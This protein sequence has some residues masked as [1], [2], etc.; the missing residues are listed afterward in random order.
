LRELGE[1]LANQG[2]RAHGIVLP[3]HEGNPERLINIGW[4]QWL[5]YTEEALA[6]L[7]QYRHV[8]LAGLSMGGVLALLLAGRHRERIAGT[9]VMSTPT[10]ISGGWQLKMLP[11]ARY[12]VKW[13]YPLSRID[14]NDP[15]M[16][17]EALKQARLRDPDV[18][19]DFSDVPTIDYMK[20]MIRIPVSAI[21]ELVRLTDMGRK[22]LGLIQSPLLIIQS[23]RDQTVNPACAE[24]L[25]HL[26]T[27]AKPKSLHWLERS[28]H[29]ITLGPEKEEVFRLCLS[30]I[31][32]VT[33]PGP[34][35][36]ALPGDVLRD[37]ADEMSP[38]H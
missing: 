6:E 14:F 8:F 22:R 21:N 16:Q 23:K 33:G 20:R 10:R 11:L 1:A 29:V 34:A 36:I 31:D 7:A 13:F 3:G 4:K 2:I 19:I 25:F 24:E 17:A 26:A 30:F 35:K 28:D 27:A 12:F 15:Q 5:A 32:D 37:E 38:G 9:I 18:V